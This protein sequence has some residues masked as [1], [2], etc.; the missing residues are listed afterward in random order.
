MK[1]VSVFDREALRQQ[2]EWQKKSCWNLEKDF[3]WNQ[4]IDSQKFFAPLD[5]NNIAF[6]GASDE[7]KLAL[8]QFMG[9]M[10]N[11][12][13]CEMECSLPRMKY[14]G[15]EK[16]LDQFPANPELY[17]LG[18][19]FFEE[20]EKH[21][22]SFQ[23]FFEI[24]CHQNNISP[25]ELK[26]LLPTGKNT[27]FQK[28]LF[29]NAGI[30]GTAFWW[31]VAAVEETSIQIYRAMIKHKANT[32]PLYF[33]L[34]KRH[35]EEEARHDNYAFMM[36][37]LYQHLPKNL[38]QKL[39]HKSDLLLSQ[40]LPGPWVLGELTKIFKVKKFAHRS[41]LFKTLSETLPLFDNMPKVDLVKGFWNQTPYVS[42]LINPAFRKK[43]LQQTESAWTLPQGS[44]QPNYDF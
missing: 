2:I 37:E 36:I 22:K 11:E 3:N 38:K 18:E 42:W 20:E 41:P 14:L 5:S 15:W 12:T 23:K 32:D 25:D 39:L 7:Q 34:H 43:G 31:T 1:P 24:F 21:A 35:A 27:L 44:K 16:L 4:G 29:W 26:S 8:S 40:V 10:I 9:L 17:E 30:G 6:P 19:L 13:I 33:Q 28:A